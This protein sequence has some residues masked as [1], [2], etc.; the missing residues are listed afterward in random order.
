M[1]T[2]VV[3]AVGLTIG[4]AA[5]AG[6]AAPAPAGT[7]P[8][9]TTSDFNA[10]AEVTLTQTVQRITNTDPGDEYDPALSGDLVVYTGNRDGDTDVYYV[11][12]TT[13]VETAVTQLPGMQELSDVYSPLITYT[14][15]SVRDV[16]V[17]DTRTGETTNVTGSS[18][19][20]AANPAIGRDTVVWEDTRDANVEIYGMDL[21][22]GIERRI[23]E[24]TPSDGAPEV[25]TGT[26]QDQVVWQVCTGGIC[27]IALY[28]WFTGATRMVTETTDA[29]ER[30][31]DMDGDI[32]VYDGYKDGERDIYA[33]DVTTRQTR[34]LT[35]AGSQNNPNISGDVVAFEDVSTGM[36][37]IM[38]WHLPTGAVL[39]LTDGLEGEYLNDIDGNRVAYTA[40]RNNQLDIYLST[41]TIE[42]S[43]DYNFTGFF[44][45]VDNDAVLN[46]AKAGSSIPV[47]FSLGGDMGLQV[48]AANSP[49][50]QQ[51]ACDQ[52][53]PTDPIETTV[54]AGGSTLT[55][56]PETGQY[57]YVW[58]TDRTWT[59]C[60]E[61]ILTLDDGSQH[62]A[63]FKFR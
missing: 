62:T 59:G 55:Y 20:F 29:D 42:E 9:T 48:L 5:V 34:R 52:G 43:S 51:V 46:V 25:S 61:F 38:L 30:R 23:T 44:P 50:S 10:G 16:W 36:Y 19:A 39:Q 6:N 57:T 26:A 3:A 21:A 22:T 35:L 2:G 49:T 17:Y 63:L 7:F 31:P 27:D 24:S 41:F 8:Y 54:T 18:G 37:R 53:V 45:P 60:R 33:Y 13:G 4:G 32:V 12:L 47:K 15:L 14:D 28:D 56:D 11:D 40:R 58:K 1:V